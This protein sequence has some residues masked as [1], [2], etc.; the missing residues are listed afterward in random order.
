MFVFPSQLCDFQLSHSQSFLSWVITATG[1]APEQCL[2]HMLALGC[3]KFLLRIVSSSEQAAE[4]QRGWHGEGF[5]PDSSKGVCSQMH[6][7]D[8]AL[9]GQVSVQRISSTR[10]ICNPFR[11]LF[12]QPRSSLTE[13]DVTSGTLETVNH[14]F[15]LVLADRSRRFFKKIPTIRLQQII[16]LIIIWNV[17]SFGKS[18]ASGVWNL[19]II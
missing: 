16:L 8:S 14:P 9:L 5:S 13:P 10:G 18:W 15:Y 17:S 4:P 1:P 12:E 19:C 11:Q 3:Q 2:C 7:S 6:D